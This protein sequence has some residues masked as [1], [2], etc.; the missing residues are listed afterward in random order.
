[1]KNK[2][3]F[4]TGSLLNPKEILNFCSNVDTNKNVH[5]VWTPESW[6]KE[7]FSL[8]GSISQVTS[9]VK[10]GTSIINVY[11]RTPATISM[12][13]ITLDILSN[14]RV[15]IGLGTSTPQLIENL[16]GMKFKHPLLR[17]REYV[18]SIKLLLKTGKTTFEGRFVKISDF[19][20]LEHSRDNIPIYVAAVNSKMLNLAKEIADG[21]IL[22]LKPKE[23]LET[24]MK[25]AERFTFNRTFTKATVI[26]T[27][28]SNSDP[29]QAVRRAAK[30][31]A[32]YISVG[33]IY[34]SYLLKTKYK[35]V[36]K[37]IYSDYHKYG[38]DESIRNITPEILNDFVIA[39]SVNDCIY[40]IK[41][42]IKTGVDLPILQ[43][44]PTIR[45]DGITSYKDFFDL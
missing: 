43:V 9:R 3:A 24:I 7:A 8:L 36:V 22:Y 38:I 20:L 21:L 2:I 25:Q 39:G 6:G 14:H 17:M 29:S 34:Y 27:S 4:S 11:T 23:E 15:I 18:E 32:F 41:G 26:I 31:F 16:H 5:S 10:I 1:M 19:E 44:N 13:A 30:T 37:K 40:Q 33:K 42:F 12:G 35:D 45:S 28:V